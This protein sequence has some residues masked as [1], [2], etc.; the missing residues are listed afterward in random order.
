MYHPGKVLKIFSP[1]SDN[2]E[3]SNDEV[4]VMVEMWDDNMI[5]L[6]LDPKLED[7]IREGDVVLA[8]YRPISDKGSPT[9]RM[10]VTKILKGEN[11]SITWDRYKEYYRKKKKE[12]ASGT[13]VMPPQ[14]YIG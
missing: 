1:K 12:A 13:R 5:V 8:D 6:L 3:S 7:K 9:P 2:I 14:S 11:G 10:I 4:Q